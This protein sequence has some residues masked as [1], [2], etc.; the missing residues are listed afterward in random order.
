MDYNAETLFRELK[1]NIRPMAREQME[2]TFLHEIFH[3]FFDNL[4]YKQHDE[5]LIDEL[6]GALYAFIRDNPAVFAGKN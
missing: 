3:A 4:G 6:A 1:I 5:K 2:R